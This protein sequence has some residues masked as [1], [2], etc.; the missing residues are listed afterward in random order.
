MLFKSRDDANKNEAGVV[1][2]VEKN[3]LRLLLNDNLV[4]DVPYNHV[5]QQLP[6]N[7]K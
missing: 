3:Y 7:M 1:I 2:K 6:K 4:E 5:I